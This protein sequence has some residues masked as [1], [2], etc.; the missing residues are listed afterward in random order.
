MLKYCPSCYTE[1]E[2]DDKVTKCPHCGEK[3]DTPFTQEEDDEM[4]E[5]LMTMIQM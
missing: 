3:L 2:V 5:L 1:V 4:M